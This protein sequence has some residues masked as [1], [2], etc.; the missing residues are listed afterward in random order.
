[1]YK[2]HYY[3]FV[4]LEL[5]ILPLSFPALHS[6]LFFFSYW[7]HPNRL[8]IGGVIFAFSFLF[9]TPLCSWF[10]SFYPASDFG[11]FFS[12]HSS[13]YSQM[14]DFII[15]YL[16]YCFLPDLILPPSSSKICYRYLHPTCCHHC[17]HPQM[18]I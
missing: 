16:D 1:M 12:L 2:N 10:P 17:I 14:Q 9:V 13:Q 11:I 7:C 4:L 8:G 18:Q 5:W 6:T 3:S 15:S